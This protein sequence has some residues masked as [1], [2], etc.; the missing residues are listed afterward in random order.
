MQQRKI[1]LIKGIDKIS[2]FRTSGSVLEA[3]FEEKTEGNKEIM[4]LS[5][6]NTS[7]LNSKIFQG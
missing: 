5:L 2:C 1:K 3:I 4:R 6:L 7:T